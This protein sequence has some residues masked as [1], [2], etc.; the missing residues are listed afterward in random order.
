LVPVEAG[1]VRPELAPSVI[2]PPYDLLNARDRAE[3]AAGN[4]RSFLHGT[5]SSESD[6]PA[7]DAARRH[8]QARAYVEARLAEEAWVFAGEVL[9]V[10]RI[11]S[12]DHTQT[13]V[14]GDVPA[15]A[16][17]GLIRPHEHT[18]PPRV[19]D[20][21][22]YLETVGVGSSPV[23]V[24]YRRQP[25]IDAI[26]SL[27]TDEPPQLD[28]VLED[29][30][31]QQVWSVSEPAVVEGLTAAFADVGS[32][33]IVDGHHR[34]AATLQRGGDP[35]TP[36]GRFLAV[37]FPHDDLAVYPFHRWLASNWSPAGSPSPAPLEVGP[38]RVVVVTRRGEW[39]L[40]LN[41][42]RDDASALTT[43]ILGPHLAVTDDRID[44][45]LTYIPGYP[46]PGA[47][48]AKVAAEG[49][50]GFL[51]HPPTVEEVMA[52][53]DRGEVMPPKA[54]FFSPKPR[55][56]VFLVKR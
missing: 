51:L 56:G 53:S 11:R 39:E 50:V 38:G 7:A 3:L 54:T 13:G 4:P 55:S 5:P 32:G 20:L 28:V 15:W 2:S 44:P 47:L 40:A 45:R 1:L 25:E 29:G 10:Y 19:A 49:G 37:V 16:F 43:L 6:D 8:H 14:V 30:D 33:Y 27:V 31:R 41:D 36:A 24:T 18:R 12:G 21:V 35:A 17:P 48:R 34:V 46:G 26:V 9:Y 52:V 22:N 23:G 42:G